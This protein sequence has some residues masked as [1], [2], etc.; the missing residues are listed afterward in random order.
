[1]SVED[2]T[3]NCGFSMCLSMSCKGGQPGW[4]WQWFKNTGV[5]AGGDRTDIGSGTSC[6]PYSLA[7]AL[8]TW[9]H[10]P[11]IR[12]ACSSLLLSSVNART[13][14]RTMICC[15]IQMRRRMANCCLRANNS[16]WN[17]TRSIPLVTACSR[18]TASLPSRRNATY[19]EASHSSFSSGS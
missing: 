2:T 3:A 1:M 8:T 12:S 4:A 17:V 16:L 11:S 18:T 5:V 7:P 9:R 10:P 6:G 14:V 15:E 13:L 19:T